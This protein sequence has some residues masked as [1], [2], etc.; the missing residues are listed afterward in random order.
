MNKHKVRDIVGAYSRA[1]KIDKN[2]EAILLELME[3]IITKYEKITPRISIATD[4]NNTYLIK[5]QNGYYSTEDFFLNRL[6]NNIWSVGLITRETI[7]EGFTSSH[8]KGQFLPRTRSLE[9]NLEKIENQVKRFEKELGNNYQEM[10]KHAYKKVIMHEFEHGLQT[11]YSDDLNLNQR[12]GYKAISDE[13]RKISLNKYNI[14]LQYYE[15]IP[16][17]VYLEN[18]FIATGVY[19]DER[20][21]GGYDGTYRHLDEVDY[22]NEILNETESLEMAEQKVYIHNYI[23]KSGNKYPARNPESSN[24]YISNYGDMFK[25][26]LGQSKSFKLMY[27]DC[28]DVYSYF[29]KL[30]T[31]IFQKAYGSNKDAIELF[32]LAITKIK[33]ENLEE[34]HLRLNEVFA[35]CLEMKVQRFF[36]DEKIQNGSL[37]VL[38]SEF[39][40]HIVKNDDATKNSQL[41]H[42]KILNDVKNKINTRNIS[43]SFAQNID[44][45]NLFRR[46]L[47]KSILDN[48]K[49]K[50]YNYLKANNLSN[51]DEVMQRMNSLSGLYVEN[52]SAR[53]G[54]LMQNRSKEIVV[55]VRFVRFDKEGNPIGWDS[56]LSKLIESELGHE[57]LHAGSRTGN[58]TGI[59]YS[60]KERALN[61]GFTQLITENI[62]GY[63]V[64]NNTDGYRNYKKYAKI[65]EATF[66]KKCVLESY[67]GNGMELQNKINTL[68]PGYYEYFN[69]ILNNQERVRKFNLNSNRDTLLTK[70]MILNIV[71]PTL[72]NKTPEEANNYVKNMALYF[73]EDLEYPTSFLSYLKDYMNASVPDMVIEK[74]RVKNK[75]EQKNERLIF[76]RQ[77]HDA[78]DINSIIRI[79]ERGNIHP[80]N[81]NVS[82]KDSQLL[83]LMYGKL[84]RQ[85]HSKDALEQLEKKILGDLQKGD[86]RIQFGSGTDIMFKREIIAIFKQVARKNNYVVTNDLATIGDE[87][88]V[89]LDVINFNEEKEKFSFDRLREYNDRYSMHYA[90]SNLRI[91]PDSYY[92][93]EIYDERNKR[94]VEDNVVNAIVPFVQLWVQAFKEINETPFGEY[95]RDVYQNIC[96]YAQESMKETGTIDPDKLCDKL[97]EKKHICADDIVYALFRTPYETSKVYR[98]FTS[99][100]PK[101]DQRLETETTKVFNHVNRD[102][103][104]YVDMLVDD[105]IPSNNKTMYDSLF[106]E[107][108]EDTVI[109][110]NRSRNNEYYYRLFADAADGLATSIS[111]DNDILINNAW[112]RLKFAE[113]KIQKVD[114]SGFDWKKSTRDEQFQFCLFRMKESLEKKDISD[115]N[116]YRDRYNDVLNGVSVTKRVS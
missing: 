55:D 69:E 6:M 24:C 3:K 64:S 44:K 110:I 2:V 93:Y 34:D 116:F 39:E 4:K 102:F 7:A 63:S 60:E 61:E 95:A 90:D 109:Y 53:H 81:G 72:K 58:I 113:S 11:R 73:A 56:N 18:N 30:Y 97:M 37:M 45:S 20:T 51:A 59:M 66:G 9:L 21:P 75:I 83:R 19:Y 94:F 92:G 16:K 112:K 5:P 104:G 78:D 84:Y 91:D 12:V 100:I 14:D 77:C 22:L 106:N 25:L 33:K 42:V 103:R 50:I 86:Y 96:D 27:F 38:V 48:I 29:N 15:D 28:R 1:L 23:G 71:I 82:I 115:Y 46:E 62:F 70:S 40:K 111:I 107:L 89:D 108:N 99:L 67:F 68:C 43:D 17:D 80:K 47:D 76:A 88:F 8:T 98:Y 79:D 85:T 36:D 32:I 10:N 87:D 101:S 41:A 65:L 13:L 114:V 35:K 26:I 52:L 105:I 57:L 74:Q 31:P 54:S 49:L